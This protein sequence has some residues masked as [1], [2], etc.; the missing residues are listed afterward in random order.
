MDM[1]E[2]IFRRA[3]EE[4]RLAILAVA[5]PRRGARLLDRGCG[6]EEFTVRVAERVGADEV[7]GVELVEAAATQEVSIRVAMCSQ[8]RRA[9]GR[10]RGLVRLSCSATTRTGVRSFPSLPSAK[11]YA[12][13]DSPA[14]SGGIRLESV[15]DKTAGRDV[16]ERQGVP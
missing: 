7:H 6:G 2:R 4:N 16:R 8:V 13:Y 5:I 14:A 10:R 1:R 11:P 12:S 3:E 15:D 9:R